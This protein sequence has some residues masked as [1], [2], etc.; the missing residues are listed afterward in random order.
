MHSIRTL[1]PPLYENFEGSGIAQMRKGRR[2][3]YLDFRL[4]NIDRAII[5]GAKCY[6][7]FCFIK[8]GIVYELQSCVRI[9][10]YVD[11]QMSERWP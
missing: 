3:M 1:C 9:S 11:A 10:C 6:L 2:Y 4:T 7:L 5:I 8:L